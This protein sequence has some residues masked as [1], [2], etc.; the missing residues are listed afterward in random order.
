M[1]ATVLISYAVQG[2]T[3][4]HD[5]DG[6]S[7]ARRDAGVVIDVGSDAGVDSGTDAPWS[8]DAGVFERR[9]TIF[10]L[11][12]LEDDQESVDGSRVLV[13]ETNLEG[14][15]IGAHPVP[16]SSFE[17]LGEGWT[18]I[19]KGKIYFGAA[20]DLNVSPDHRVFVSLNSWGYGYPRWLFHEVEPAA[21]TW[22]AFGPEPRS[23]NYV[24]VDTNLPPVVTE[25]GNLVGFSKHIL[26]V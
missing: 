24:A 22:R 4:S 16:D 23:S 20:Y 2:C 19:G 10:W 13:V 26:A 14:G 25:A 1:L 17:I 18:R 6:G 9:D 21:G 5:F 8:R 12:G 11:M 7:H 15:L 3:A